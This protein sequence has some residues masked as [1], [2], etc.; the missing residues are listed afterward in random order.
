MTREPIPLESM[1]GA[2]VGLGKDLDGYVVELLQAPEPR[3]KTLSADAA[4]ASA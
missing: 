2:L 1:G 3:D 4:R